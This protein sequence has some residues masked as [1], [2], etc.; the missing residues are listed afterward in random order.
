MSPTTANRPTEN[1][2]V[3]SALPTTPTMRRSCLY[4]ALSCPPYGPRSM[5]GFAS[6]P[7]PRCAVTALSVDIRPYGTPSATT[8]VPTYV[9]AAANAIRPYG[10]QSPSTQERANSTA[11][12]KGVS[13]R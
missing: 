8:A 4:V 9:V 7:N 11:T 13:G 3:T 6:Y 5:G 10:E 12:M 2:A 1:A